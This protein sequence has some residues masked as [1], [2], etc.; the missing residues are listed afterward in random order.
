M[1]IVGGEMMTNGID[2]DPLKRAGIP[3]LGRW[4]P[5]VPVPPCDFPV[6]GI[7]GGNGLLDHGLC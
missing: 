6:M 3:S 1:R 5:D 7:V 2:G 4:L